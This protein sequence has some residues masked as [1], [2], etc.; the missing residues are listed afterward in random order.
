[1]LRDQPLHSH[2]HLNAAE[3]IVERQR[4]QRLNDLQVAII[5]KED[6]LHRRPVPDDLGGA[7][8][9]NVACRCSQTQKQKRTARRQ[10]T[11]GPASTCYPEQPETRGKIV[12]RAWPQEA[13]AAK[14]QIER[15]D[16]AAI[17]K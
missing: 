15:L 13:L 17:R 9:A 7:M 3:A 6:V 16:N 8:A 12:M 14:A 5:G 1:M 2:R 11:S 4:R 10:P